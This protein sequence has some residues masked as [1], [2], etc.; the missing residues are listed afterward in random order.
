MIHKP[1][2][3]L[4]YTLTDFNNSFMILLNTENKI[5]INFTHVCNHRISRRDIKILEKL[6]NKKW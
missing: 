2:E 5:P 6:L 3:L 1:T 4:Y